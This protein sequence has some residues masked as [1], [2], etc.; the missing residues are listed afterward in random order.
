MKTVPILQKT[1]LAFGIGVFA[2]GTFVPKSNAQEKSFD[3][4]ARYLMDSSRSVSGKGPQ[5][6]GAEKSE[7]KIQDTRY[8]IAHW[9]MGRKVF[10]NN[11]KNPMPHAPE[12]YMVD[13]V[14]ACLDEPDVRPLFRAYPDLFLSITQKLPF[15]A[16]SGLSPAARTFR[17]LSQPFVAKQLQADPVSFQ[18]VVDAVRG[19]DLP[20]LITGLND[21]AR[22][23][24]ND[25][26]LTNNDSTPLK[27]TGV[28]EAAIAYYSQMISGLAK[29]Y[30][31]VYYARANIYWLSKRYAEAIEDYSH[32]IPM[33][34]EW[35]YLE[36][37]QCYARR[38][39]CYRALGEIQK[40]D[41]DFKKEK[42]YLDLEWQNYRLA[43]CPAGFERPSKKS[44]THHKTPK[45]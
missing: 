4:R 3:P 29:Y 7:A 27:Y 22:A 25:Y 1:M 32:V 2:L 12:P 8:R 23:E 30:Y 26:F 15:D 14:L 38:G 16:V 13:Q 28:K 24:F 44:K 6:P 11:M 33:E 20:G 36:L 9:L 10:S 34:L 19:E 35:N 17:L 41:E 39:M 37:S 5:V 45:K 21:F 43:P 42:E 31:P 18:Q 40:A